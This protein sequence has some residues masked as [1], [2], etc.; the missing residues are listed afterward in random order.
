[1]IVKFS[2][3]KTNHILAVLSSDTLSSQSLGRG[4]RIASYNFITS[5]TVEVTIM[6]DYKWLNGENHTTHTIQISF[7][8]GYLLGDLHLRTRRLSLATV[9][10]AQ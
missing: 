8:Y 2:V 5:S 1:M 4:V 7:P 9:T 3:T 10:T 6:S